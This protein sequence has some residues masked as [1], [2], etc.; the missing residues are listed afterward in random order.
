MWSL[1][2]PDLRSAGGEISQRCVN[3]QIGMALAFHVEF[4]TSSM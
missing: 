1:I 3:F 2:F 4:G